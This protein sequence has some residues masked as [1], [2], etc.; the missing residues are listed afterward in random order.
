M[1]WRCKPCCCG[2]GAGWVSLRNTDPTRWPSFPQPAHLEKP[3]GLS[4]GWEHP[5]VMSP[6]LALP[7]SPRF[8]VGEHLLGVFNGTWVEIASPQPPS[9]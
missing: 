7:S 5:Q 4:P 2:A 3:I 9:R 8:H 6:A 1:S